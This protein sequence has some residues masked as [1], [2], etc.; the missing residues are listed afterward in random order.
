MTDPASLDH[1][2]KNEHYRRT[3]RTGTTGNPPSVAYR[4]CCGTSIERL[5]LT[6]IL[7]WAVVRCSWQLQANRKTCNSLHQQPPFPIQR[8]QKA[9]WRKTSISYSQSWH[10]VVRPSWPVGADSIYRETSTLKQMAVETIALL[11]LLAKRPTVVQ[12]QWLWVSS[13]LGTKLPFRARTFSI[14]H[15]ASWKKT[16]GQNSRS[17]F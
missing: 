10:P 5:V 7:R 17:V 2:C 6:V 13:W 14:L 15:P 12:S 8:Y 9:D 3:R 11:S 16:V 4:S 1:K